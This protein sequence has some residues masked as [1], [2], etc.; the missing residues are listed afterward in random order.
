[1]EFT[2]KLVSGTYEIYSSSARTTDENADLARVIEDVHSVTRRLSYS[3]RPAV[4]DDE[5]A[6]LGLVKE[7][8]KLSEDL[9]R[10]LKRLQTKKPMSKSE[11]FRVAWRAIREKGDLESL[12]KRL[13]RYRRQILDR[14]VIM[15]RWVPR[16]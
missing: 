7:C 13:E 16:W 3:A 14:I 6:L 9:V 1:V 2:S 8:R 10:A 15:M 12:E 11:S 5:T 4:T